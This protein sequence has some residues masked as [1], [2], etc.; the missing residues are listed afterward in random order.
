MYLAPFA[1]KERSADMHNFGRVTS[2]LFNAQ[3]GLS[4][5]GHNISNV[6]TAG[7]T[8]QRLN[9]ADAPYRTVGYNVNGAMRVGLGATIHSRVQI[10]DAFL[11]KT[12]RTSFSKASF[13]GTNLEVV[14]EMENI[15]GELY[16]DAALSKNIDE[17]WSA[18]QML[19][20]HPDGFETRAMFI[21]TAVRF[22]NKTNDIA[23]GMFEYQLKLNNEIISGVNR[24]NELSTQIA[25]L[26]ARI[27]RA[28]VAGDNANDFRDAR[29]MLVDE[30]SGFGRVDLREDEFGRIA[31]LLEGQDLV[32]GTR[33]NMLGLRLVSDGRSPEGPTG[34]PFVEPVFN[35]NYPKDGRILG[36][37][38]GQSFRP[39]FTDLDRGVS[40]ARDNDNGS[41]KSL[42]L[43]R[44]RQ[45]ANHKLEP[46][47][48]QHY[49]IPKLQREFDILVNSIV[50]LINDHLAPQNK[51]DPNAPFDLNGGQFTEL[52]SRKYVPRYDPVTG[53]YIE[54]GSP[55]ALD[56]RRTLYS[57]GNLDKP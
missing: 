20:T 9:I 50:R 54:E 36:F 5:T 43:A 56:Y 44:G 51:D 14:R 21:Q 55:P 46:E 37:E 30:L 53:L 24:I 15:L 31:V 8:R 40:Q 27:A 12:Y 16:G 17:M 4:T 57:M 32:H 28:E 47:E 34:Y 29:N 25:D 49:T 6:R 52:F 7:Y 35:P 22:V 19:V 38:E 2:G 10:R 45:P 1:P 11:D 41:L 18:L 48:V 3:A 42:M 23:N 13:H 26:N 39:L 33:A